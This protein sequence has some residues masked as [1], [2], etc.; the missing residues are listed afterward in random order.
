MRS[1]DSLM[2]RIR[3]RQRSS[4][5]A[6]SPAALASRWRSPRPLPVG[7]PA[8]VLATLLTAAVLLPSFRVTS[9]L[10]NL[11]LE[12]LLWVCALPYLAVAWLLPAIDSAEAGTDADS[13]RGRLSA[14]ARRLR[15]TPI[16]AGFL[17]LGAVTL[18]SLLWASL[19]LGERVG[20]R[21]GYE[22]VKLGLYWTAFRTALVVAGNERTRRLAL[23]C[24]LVAGSLSA[25]FALAQYFDWFGIVGGVGHWWAE[26]HHVRGLERDGRSFGTVGNPNYFGALMTMLAVVALHTAARPA[27][28]WGPRWAAYTALALGALGV[29]L[30]GSRGA[31][32][33]LVVAVSVSLA[34]T[35]LVGRWR[36]AGGPVLL[37]LAAVVG[38][39]VLVQAFPQGRQ[40]YLSR[41]AG[42]FSATGDSAVA[43]RLERWRSALGIGSEHGSGDR[44][45]EARNYIKN[46][47]LERTAGER[48]ARFSALPGTAYRVA[49][50]AA[51]F[52]SYGII[53]RGNPDAPEKRAAVYQQ[54]AI[55][56]SGG[57]P[58]VASVWVKFPA[59]VQGD[60]Y[61]YTNV[62]YTDGD[63]RDPYA[64]VAADSSLVGV[65]QRLSLTIAPDPGR[66]VDFVGVYLLTDGFEGEVYADGFELVDGSPAEGAAGL[67]ATGPAD[68]PGLDVGAQLRRS[69]IFGGGP[70]KAAG[71][72]TLDN[73][74]LLVV[75]RY[76]LAGL[77][78]YLVLWAAVIAMGIGAVRRGNSVAAALVGLV[79]GL[80]LFNLVAGSLYQLQ[81]MAVFWPLAGV[82]LAP[83]ATRR[84][85]PSRSRN[86][87]PSPA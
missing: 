12:L 75:A 69:P 42:A 74:Y 57:P 41:V 56:R 5:R 28:G 30:S 36:A 53:Y 16:D 39:V 8:I 68:S 17:A 4:P 48:A 86:G 14:I 25:L 7:W 80:L 1:R 22:I 55:S 76:G 31:L 27:A 10:I 23:T 70:G 87:P 51:R 83:A 66:R 79:A 15:L 33:M 32:G 24:F 58:L 49:P 2:G 82:L 65:W 38:S 67:P 52:G 37:L 44:P 77:V 85:T 78:A 62:F 3:S 13:S 6:G 60:V 29:V 20:P 40:G 11:R 43:L 81:V 21:D 84:D 19:V 54:R 45:G 46:G 71:A 72:G 35:L 50:E 64:R 73:E 59:P 9:N 63:R 47:D 34:V 26:A 18:L 61:L